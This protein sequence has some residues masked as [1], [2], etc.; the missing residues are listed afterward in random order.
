MPRDYRYGG[1]QTAMP[2]SIW[3][4]HVTVAALVE[5]N[6][7]FLVVRELINGREVINQPAGHLDKGESL[8][9]AVV[10]E[11]LE[12]TQYEFTATGLQGIYRSIADDDPD[13]TYLR[14]LFCGNI[15][16]HFNEALDQGIIAAEWL[17][18]DEVRACQHQHRSP[19]VLQG[20]EDYLNQPPCPLNVIS[21]MFA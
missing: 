16:Q 9:D 2:D 3:K 6:D 7:K 4:P 12:E 18:L 21:Q 5:Q 14:F 1:K 15:G 20:I 19:L 11:M 13:I 8:L 10:R 17:N